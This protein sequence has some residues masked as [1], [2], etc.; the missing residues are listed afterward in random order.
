M[1]IANN[2]AILVGQ[3]S[4][5]NAS[6]AGEIEL[7]PQEPSWATAR[8]ARIRILRVQETIEIRTTIG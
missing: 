5:Q 2:K 3:A 6:G 4:V 7:R 1:D 8:K